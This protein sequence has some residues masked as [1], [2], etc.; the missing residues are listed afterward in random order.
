VAFDNGSPAECVIYA[1]Y[2]SMNTKTKGFISTFVGYSP[3]ADVVAKK[4]K[5]CLCLTKH[6][7]MKMYGRVDV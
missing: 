2:S 5:L 3:N 6:Y 4:R 1:G 7:A